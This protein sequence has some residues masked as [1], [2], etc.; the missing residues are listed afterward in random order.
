MSNFYEYIGC[1]HIHLPIKHYNEFIDNIANDAENDSVDFIFLSP[2]TP[3]TI[4][5]KQHT[6]YFQKEGYYGRTMVFTGEE[7]DEQSDKNHIISYGQKEWVGKIGFEKSIPII[8]NSDGLTF[9]AHPFGRH[10]IFI[11]NSN[12]CWNKGIIK[13]TGIEVWSLLFDLVQNKTLFT[14]PYNYLRFPYNL[15]GPDR[16]TLG[17]WDMY[18]KTNKTVGIAGLDIHKLPQ[19]LKMFDIKRAITYRFVFKVLRNHVLCKE[20][21]TGAFEK[22]KSIILESVKAGRLFIANDFL[23]DSS[24]FFMENPQGNKTMGDVFSQDE[25]I[26]IN[27]PCKALILM[28]MNGK[29]LWVKETK[30]YKISLKEK[31]VYRAEIFLGNTPWIFTNPIFVV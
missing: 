18:L 30:E 10:R 27:L 26:F 22:D 14:L 28:K 17:F 4:M 23:M 9:I 21:L 15:R 3:E 2:H 29:V 25:E 1:F 20:K 13:I 6:D 7:I 12:H 31:G 19:F 24:G 8:N 16:K 11:L 5:E